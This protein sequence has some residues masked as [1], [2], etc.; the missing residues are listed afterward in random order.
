MN[1]GIKK[2]SNKNLNKKEIN[3]QNKN[4][5]IKLYSDSKIQ[6]LKNLNN[7]C[8]LDQSN[9]N[10]E[11]LCDANNSFSE[12]NIVVDNNTNFDKSLKQWMI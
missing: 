5:D 12:L 10:S 6:D 4:D 11:N 2:S 1:N 9:I 8:V 7:F 3:G